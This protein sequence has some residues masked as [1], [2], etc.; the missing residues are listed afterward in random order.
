LHS[1][2]GSGLERTPFT[3]TTI[4]KAGEW[5]HPRRIVDG[6]SVVNAI[7]EGVIGY[8]PRDIFDRCGELN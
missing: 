7:I 3:L 4:T 8:G 6:A 2:H 5:N 1:S